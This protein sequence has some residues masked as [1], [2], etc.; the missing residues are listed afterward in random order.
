MSQNCH[1]SYKSSANEKIGYPLSGLWLALTLAFA[2]SCA[3]V[4]YDS[5]TAGV[6]AVRLPFVRALLTDSATDAIVGAEGSIVIE[7]V[8]GSQRFVYYSPR[9]VHIRADHS[10]LALLNS[11]GEVIEDDLDQ[12][13][14][15]S[16]RREKVLL[17]NGNPYRGMMRAHPTDNNLL[18][19]NILYIEDYLKGVVPPELGP[20]KSEDSAAIKAQAIAARTYTMAHLGQYGSQPYDVKSDVSDQ[21]YLG[22]RVEKNIISRAVD[23][24][25]G[26]VARYDG[27]FVTAYYHSTCGG[28][29]DDIQNV[30]PR[31]AQPYLVGVDCQEMCAPSKYYR[32]KE[33]FSGAELARRIA[34][35]RSNSTGKKINFSVLNDISLGDNISSN[36]D[37]V[38]HEGLRTQEL[39]VTLDEQPLRFTKDN[40]RWVVRRASDPDKI[41][42]S[43]YFVLRDIKRE[44]NG[45]ISSVTF[46]GKGYGHGVGM[47]QMGALGMARSGK[48]YT[49]GDILRRYYAGITIDR[50]Y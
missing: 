6:R 1:L 3:P 34:Q 18:I 45:D 22:S 30:W 48:N 24:T 14:V 8:R 29:T 43:D 2:V 26:E 16:R 41:L 13:T 42:Q 49:Y 33:T 36:S 28:Y 5:E 9:S 10:Y 35:F 20:V 44:A 47:C 39:L 25:Q 32:W 17:I 31:K 27:A 15:S 37:V 7:C 21:L 19:T 11:A 4:R 46:A 23:R 38:E 12:V 40:I 50:L